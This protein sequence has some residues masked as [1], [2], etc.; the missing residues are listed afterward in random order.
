MVHEAKRKREAGVKRTDRLFMPIR[1]VTTIVSTNTST[2]ELQGGARQFYEAW[3]TGAADRRTK[4]GA[5]VERDRP[6]GVC[7][8]RGHFDI[9]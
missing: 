3:S 4:A 8:D 7:T 1:G 6:R 5:R 9:A 2:K